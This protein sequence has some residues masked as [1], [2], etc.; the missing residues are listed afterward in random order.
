MRLQWAPRAIQEFLELDPETQRHVNERLEEL[1]QRG[2]KW[3][4][5]R[6]IKRDR[7]DL[8]AHRLKID[9]DQKDQI[10]HRVIFDVTEGGEYKI[11]KLGRRPEFY[12]LENLVEAQKRM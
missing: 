5:V 9:P 3:E 4:K 11:I 10:N 12:D 1:P 6:P 7:I 2:L 8:S